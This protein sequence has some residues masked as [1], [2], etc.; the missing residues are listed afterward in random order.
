[1]TVQQQGSVA[2][3]IDP[4]E[5]KWAAIVGDH[6]VPLPRQLMLARD[7]L[8]Q[9]GAKP[10]SILVRDFNSPFDIG[11]EADAEVDLSEGN[12]FR[13]VEACQSSYEIRCDAPPKLGFVVDDRWEITVRARQTG[14]TLR[15]LLQVSDDAALLRDR[16][17]PQDDFI[18][19]E[20][21]FEF[22][23]GPVFITRPGHAVEVTIIV[24][25]R[26]KV[27]K[28]RVLTFNEVVALAFDPVPTGE[29]ILFTITYKHGPRANPEGTL[30]EGDEVKIKER[31]I[32]NVKHTDKS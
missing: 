12:V 21:V 3:R 10:G 16:E 20:D 30:V 27:V 24:N 19:D 1:M 25:G 22:A 23:D 17:S 6:L 8:H 9:A 28:K 32:F 15:A 13:T 5:V 18:D 7:I 29:N 2:K 4:A 31:M 14:E 11:F 26:K